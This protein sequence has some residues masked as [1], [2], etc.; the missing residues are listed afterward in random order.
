MTHSGFNHFFFI[1][2]SFAA[3]FSAV[4]VADEHSSPQGPIANAGCVK[5]L[6]DPSDQ[7][8]SIPLRNLLGHFPQFKQIVQPITT[9]K[10]GEVE[11]CPTTFY[12]GTRYETPIPRAFYDDVAATKNTVVWMGYGVYGYSP[13]KQVELFGHSFQGFT[14]LDTEHRD[15]KGR[16]TFFKNVLYKG[17]VFDKYG[18][19]NE[20]RTRFMSSPQISRIKQEGA[21]ANVLAEIEH[22]FTHDRVPYAIQK[23][24]RYY[25]VE[26]PFSYRHESDRYLVIADLLFDILKA[27]PTYSD[28]RPALIRVED[29]NYTTPDDQL[30]GLVEGLNALGVPAEMALIPIFADPLHVTGYDPSGLGVAINEVPR[31]AK[32]IREFQSSGTTI[33]WHGVTHQYGKHR[34]PHGVSADDFEFVDIKTG[35]PIPEDSVDYVL[36]L[37]NRGWDALSKAGVDPEIWEVPHYSASSL[38]YLMF[39]RLFP[40]NYG[41][42]RYTAYTARGVPGLTNHKLQYIETGLLADGVRRKAFSNLKVQDSNDTSTQFFPYEI[43]GDVYGQRVIPENLGEGRFASPGIMQR[44]FADILDFARRNRVIRDSWSSMYIHVSYLNKLDAMAPPTPGRGAEMLQDLILRM[45]SMGYEYINLKDFMDAHKDAPR[46][47]VEIRG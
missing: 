47:E 8:V 14:A 19:Y 7:Y 39:A 34:N 37:M 3:M 31:F 18:E 27:A 21:G 26:N 33:V 36:N 25:I 24:N 28:K 1:L 44:T 20:D 29:V 30:R 12:I 2:S 9:Y 10:K 4:G 5:I 13:A 23:G 15:D 38:D 11:E 17:E 35:K 32:T 16:P 46:P 45:Q 41:K 22:D 42:V 43:Y 40:W 6:H